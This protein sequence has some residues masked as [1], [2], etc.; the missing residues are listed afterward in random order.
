VGHWYRVT[1]S[2]GDG[3]GDGNAI[4]E[5]WYLV[6]VWQSVY[7]EEKLLNVLTES[8]SPFQIPLSWTDPAQSDVDL[9]PDKFFAR[10]AETN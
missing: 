3:D 4:G 8:N 2:F 9:A 10:E 7:Y 6:S 1:R 5:R